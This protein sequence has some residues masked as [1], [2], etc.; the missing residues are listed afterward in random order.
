MIAPPPRL[1]CTDACSWLEIGETY[2]V[3]DVGERS[4]PHVERGVVAHGDVMGKYHTRIVGARWLLAGVPVKGFPGIR[5]VTVPKSAL[6]AGGLDDDDSGD[7]AGGSGSATTP[8][9]TSGSSVQFG[10]EEFAVTINFK[11]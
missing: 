6:P 3:D 8:G 10:S 11:T 2:L 4:L 1:L 7:G 5:D 9:L